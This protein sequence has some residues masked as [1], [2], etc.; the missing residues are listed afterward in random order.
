M[1]PILRPAYEKINELKH[2]ANNQIGL[3]EILRV[4]KRKEN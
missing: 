2:K 1:L 4:R 3:Q